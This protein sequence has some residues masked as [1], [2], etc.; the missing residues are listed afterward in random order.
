[1]R[2]TRRGTWEPIGL[3]ALA[4]LL[5]VVACSPDSPNPA[6]PLLSPITARLECSGRGSD[7]TSSKNGRIAFSR[8]N[9]AT[10]SFV[11]FTTKA[12]GSDP[13]Q[14]TAGGSTFDDNQAEWSPDG[15][16]LVFE[17]DYWTGISQQLFRVNAD[18]SGLTQLFDC[19]GKCLGVSDPIYS[20][21]GK[22]IAFD[23]A[24][25]DDN[26]VSVGIWIMNADGS[27][28]RQATNRQAGATG[29]DH[30]AS[31]SPD[32]R[33]LAFTRSYY[34]AQ[35]VRQAIFVSNLDG[36]DLHRITPWQLNAYGP[37]WSPDGKL[38]LFTS[39]YDV[40]PAGNEQLFTVHPDGSDLKQVVP[41]GLGQPSNESGRFSPDGKKIVFMHVND[42]FPASP[43]YTMNLD[44]SDVTM[45][46]SPAY[47]NQYPA[48][49]T[50][51]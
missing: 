3:S 44:G 17:R 26:Y 47:Q 45:I 1:M 31:F 49:G 34:N 48:W 32:G 24:N 39:H 20:P 18:G 28:Q 9:D 15:S 42:P 10:G 38:I 33:K 36:S 29:E 8:G 7:C 25:G 30:Y 6:S 19:S 46:L 50:H 41:S 4:V 40:E 12:D 16:T 11:L 43:I 23:E 14:L 35:P 5:A 21:D 51:K 27:N 13:R 37:D 22:S 2:Y